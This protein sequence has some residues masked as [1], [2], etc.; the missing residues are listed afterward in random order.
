MEDKEKNLTSEPDLD[1]YDE[2]DELD[3]RRRIQAA[4]QKIQAERNT[5]RQNAE[6][7]AAGRERTEQNDAGHRKMGEEHSRQRFRREKKISRR[8]ILFACMGGTILVLLLAVLALGMSKRKGSSGTGEEGREALLSSGSAALADS[9]ELSENSSKNT[10]THQAAAEPAEDQEITILAAGDNLIHQAINLQY[11]TVDGGYDYTPAYADVKDEISQADIAYVNSETPM[12]GDIFPVSGYPVFNTP[13]QNAD[14]LV[15]AG[16]DIV[17]QGNNHACDMGADGIARTL[18]VWQERNIPVTGMYQDD[19]D[20]HTMRIIEKNGIRVAFLGFIEM[21][22]RDIPDSYQFVF[23]QDED[24]VKSLI[25]EAKQQADL[26]VVSV[27]WGT[28]YTTVL[29]ERQLDMGQKMA[30]WGADIIFGSHPHVIQKLDVLTRES[31]GRKV[32]II[33]SLSNFI[34]AMPW[35]QELL[36][37]FLTV[38]VVKDG[39]TG[40][41][42][43]DSMQFTPLVSWYGDC[44]SNLHV[45][46]FE[47]LDEAT[48]E[49]HGIRNTDSVLTRDYIQTMVDECIPAQYQGQFGKIE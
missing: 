4:R 32:P 38:K 41:I 23:I 39:A 42:Y 17:N 35:K 9:N 48:A 7:K 25:E 11:Q 20:L 15:D 8:T 27:H 40:E 10:S 19:A 31:D 24:K 16:F 30:D 6:Q 33:Y 37:G 22:N 44:Y 43:P 36:G 45:V 12:A 47:T 14:A 21:M 46:R 28:E 2:E 1:E 3:V 49:Q 18:Q 34:S 5:D 13:P 26:V 29:S